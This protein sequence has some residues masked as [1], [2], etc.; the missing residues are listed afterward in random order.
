M[1]FELSDKGKKMFPGGILKMRNR[2]WGLFIAYPGE[3]DVLS[4]ATNACEINALCQMGL[5]QEKPEDPGQAL[6]L[7][8]NKDLKG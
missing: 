4:V 7:R 6:F 3:A 2:Y 8:L 1:N 5:I